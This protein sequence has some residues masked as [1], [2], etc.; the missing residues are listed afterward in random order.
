M[1]RLSLAAT[2]VT[3]SLSAFSFNAQAQ[4]KGGLTCPKGPV[5]AKSFAAYYVP[6]KNAVTLFFYKDALSEDELDAQM[7]QRAKFDAGDNANGPGKGKPSKYSQYVFKAWM[8]TKQ[9]PGGTVSLAEFAKGAY[10][11]YN[12]ESNERT[13][14][15]DFKEKEAKIKAAFPAFSVELKQGGKAVVTSKGSW[16]GDPKDKYAVKAAWDIQGTGKVR[17]YE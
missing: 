8:R 10:F 13:V 14:N 11:S 17:V 15:Y 3:A 5:E 9:K 2:I 12:C 1:L 6:A 16:S 7:A 4:T